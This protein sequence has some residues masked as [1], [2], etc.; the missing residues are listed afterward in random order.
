MNRRHFLIAGGG[1]VSV[2][3]IRMA[4]A[5]DMA[6][7][8]LSATAITQVFGTGQRLTAVAIAYDRPVANASVAAGDFA[9]DGRTVMRAYARP[10]PEPAPDGADGAFVI[11]ELDPGD[12]GAATYAALK[13]GATLTA[14]QAT[15]TQTAPL[16]A[17]DGHE[18]APG[19]PVETAGATDPLVDAFEQRSYTHPPTG[20]TLPYNLFIPR[21]YDP[22]RSYPLVNFMHDAGV[23]SDN[24]L[25]TLCQGLGAVVWV[26]PEEQA[27]RPCFVLAP[28][29]ADQVVN[30]ESD[31]SP[32]ADVMVDLVLSLAG[33]FSLDRTRL[34]TT[35]QSGGG[36]LSI[37]IGIRYPGF[38]AASY[39]VACQWAAGKC[40]PL[41][42]QKMWV[43]VSEGDVKAFPGQN[44]IMQVLRGEGAEIATARWDARDTTGE[45]SA[46]ADSLAAEGAPIL[47]ATFKPGTVILPGQED[48]PGPN[49]FNTWRVAYEIA[50]IREWLFRQSGA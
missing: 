22:G 27:V 32:Y 24:P 34:Y 18:I 35:G 47:Y 10:S 41:A 6:A 43:L 5:E 16:R 13:G 20:I 33:E 4:I 25:M 11:V 50:G 1:A 9:V 29:F 30:D 42:T 14:A 45:L 26:R 28:Q 37:A 40:G 2:G 44:A 39:L 3:R 48:G 7:H 49:H 19:G 12:R 23:S 15:V 38:F 17:A 36:M 31:D 21:D 46:Q 8:V